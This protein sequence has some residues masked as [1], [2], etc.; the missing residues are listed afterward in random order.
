MATDTKSKVTKNVNKLSGNDKRRAR[1]RTK[2]TDELKESLS[3]TARAAG[4]TAE[5]LAADVKAGADR[6]A[7]KAR[8]AK[9]KAAKR[10]R[11]SDSRLSVPILAA[12]A[13]VVAGVLVTWLRGRRAEDEET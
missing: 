10:R 5:V 4:H 11:K 8:K 3:T 12:A 2:A 7:K 6:A 1:E 13:T 9:A